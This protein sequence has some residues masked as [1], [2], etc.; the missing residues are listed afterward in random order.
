MPIFGRKVRSVTVARAFRTRGSARRFRE[1]GSGSAWH[2]SRSAAAPMSIRLASFVV[3][4]AVLTAGALAVY[5]VERAPDRAPYPIAAIP[6]GSPPLTSGGE[7]LMSENGETLPPNHPPIGGASP[8][9]SFPAAVA[10]TPALSWTMPAGWQQAPNPNAMRLAT[11]RAPGGAEVSV[12]RAGGAPEAN[13]ER[14]MS[15]FDNMGREGRVEKTV[16]GLHVI[17]VDVTGT[18]LGGGMGGGTAV[19][20]QAQPRADWAMVGAIVETPGLPYFFKMTGPAMA[21]R[22]ARP[23]FD[24]LIDGVASM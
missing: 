11:Y 14:W 10:D 5:G 9:G 23:A 4:P 8:H 2:A 24:R 18:Y 19:A 3:I 15:Q 20:A 6:A 13:I 16:H 21:I 1:A 7:G 17:T 12:S 22:A